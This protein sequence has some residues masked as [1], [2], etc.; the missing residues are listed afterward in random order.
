MLIASIAGIVE[1][2][3]QR[4]KQK[5]EEDDSCD[6]CHP[7]GFHGDVQRSNA[8]DKDGQNDA[9]VVVIDVFLSA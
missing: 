3:A 4:R 2:F 6:D 1:L 5:H 9:F 7:P 8:N